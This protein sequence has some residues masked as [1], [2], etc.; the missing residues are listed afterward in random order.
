ML[1]AVEWFVCLHA[2]SVMPD[3]AFQCVA[4]KEPSRQRCICITLIFVH[5]VS[6][7]ITWSKYWHNFFKYTYLIM[8]I[9]ISFNYFTHTLFILITYM[10][11]TTA[12]WT[13]VFISI[14]SSKL[15]QLNKFDMIYCMVLLRGKDV[16]ILFSV[17][18]NFTNTPCNE[19]MLW[20]FGNY[21]TRDD[22]DKKMGQAFEE[23]AGTKPCVAAYSV[24]ELERHRSFVLSFA[25]VLIFFFFLDI[26]PN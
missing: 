17:I 12:L 10:H 25:E 11:I 4:A 3:Q 24:C 1:P 15:K 6:S 9:L 26:L 23:V 5:T 21:K 2:Q 13:Y 16:F 20:F 19:I 18:I 7:L 22:K 14:Y 8:A